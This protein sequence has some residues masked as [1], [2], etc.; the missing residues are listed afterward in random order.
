MFST[1]CILVGWLAIGVE[2]KL[3]GSMGVLVTTGG[4]E[5]G[6]SHADISMA[7]RNRV[8]AMV[9]PRFVRDMEFSSI[10]NKSFSDGSISQ[11]KR[12]VVG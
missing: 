9:E 12:Q 6:C 10:S 4:V 7:T 1:S 11:F 5:Y 3:L 8:E 2:K